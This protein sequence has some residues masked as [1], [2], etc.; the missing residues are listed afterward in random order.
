MLIKI[1]SSAF[2]Q[3]KNTKIFCFDTN[4]IKLFFIFFAKKQSLPICKHNW[5]VYFVQLF[6]VH[7]QKEKMILYLYH[8]IKNILIT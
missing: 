7:F 8:Y 4:W 5:F 2:L 1:I 6:Y 3:E